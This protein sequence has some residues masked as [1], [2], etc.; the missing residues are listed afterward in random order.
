MMKRREFITLLGG[1]RRRG[2]SRRAHTAAG[3]PGGLSECARAR[4]GASRRSSIAT[5]ASSLSVFGEDRQASIA[6]A[7]INF[8]VSC[9]HHLP[10]LPVLGLVR[11]GSGLTKSN[12]I[13]LIKARVRSPADR[14]QLDQWVTRRGLRP[15]PF[16]RRRRL[17]RKGG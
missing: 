9:L 4:T 12:E 10:T 11:C 1:G 13:K 7:P 17:R 8:D 6:L 14:A 5:M 3:A 16:T 2:R 15:L